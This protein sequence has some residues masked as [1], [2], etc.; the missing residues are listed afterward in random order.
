M[1]FLRGFLRL[2]ELRSVINFVNKKQCIKFEIMGI[3]LAV[4]WL[5]LHAPNAGVTGSIPGWGTNSLHASGHSVKKEFCLKLYQNIKF[6]DKISN[7]KKKRVGAQADP[8]LYIKNRAV[9]SSY[10]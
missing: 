9:P 7:K 2:N 5:I 10:C 1:I 8:G 6:P 3:S 4:Q